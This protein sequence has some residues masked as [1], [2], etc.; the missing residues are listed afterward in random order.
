MVASSPFLCPSRLRRSL[1]RSR[2][3]CFTRPNRRACSQAMI[4]LDVNSFN[5]NSP[6]TIF[7]EH[8]ITGGVFTINLALAKKKEVKSPEV[9]PKLACVASASVWFRSKEI[10]RKGTFGFYRAR[11]ETRAKKSLTLVPLSSLLNRTK[12]LATQ[13]N[14]K[15]KKR[16]LIIESDSSQESRTILRYAFAVIEFFSSS[17]R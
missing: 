10:L 2:E 15:R 12:T 4:Y 9:D 14:P 8:Y 7:Q 11:N 5:E 3:T 13:A 17:S 1:A 6:Q 16:R